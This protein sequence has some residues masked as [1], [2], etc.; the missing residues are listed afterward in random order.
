MNWALY[1]LGQ[2]P[3]AQKKVHGELDEVFGTFSVPP[4]S[5]LKKWR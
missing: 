1:W 3:E 5:R 4:L 2:N